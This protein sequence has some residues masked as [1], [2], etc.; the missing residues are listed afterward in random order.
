MTL[1][2]GLAVEERT[3]PVRDLFELVELGLVSLVCLIVHHTVGRIVEANRGPEDRRSG[4]GVRRL[5][6]L[7]LSRARRARAEKDVVRY[8]MIPA[9]LALQRR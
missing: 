5:P 9:K 3:E 1:A 4:F 6:L 8:R 2:A 7:D